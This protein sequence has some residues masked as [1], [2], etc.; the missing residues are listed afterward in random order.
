MK[1]IFKVF[2][3]FEANS[4]LFVLGL[5]PKQKALIN[6]CPKNG[7]LYV[8]G[9][10]R[11]WLKDRQVT[12]FVLKGPSPKLSRPKFNENQDIDDVTKIKIWTHG[13]TSS[14]AH[15]PEASVH[16]QS[17]STI[18]ACCA[19]GTSSKDSLL[20][21]VRFLEREVPHLC[22]VQILFTLKQLWSPIKPLSKEELD[23]QPYNK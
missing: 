10:F 3:S 9:A 18:L 8:E 6:R 19:T 5:S 7:T 13:E 11:V 12:Y 14:H 2:F 16:E 1:S 17:D 15:I 22:N 21:W 23:I 4:K 20:S